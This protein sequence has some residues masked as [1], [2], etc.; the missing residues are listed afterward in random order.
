MTSRRGLW[1]LAV[2][3]LLGLLVVGKFAA[4]RSSLPRVWARTVPV[5]PSDPLR[6]RYVR[7][8][9]DAEDHRAAGDSTAGVEFFA[10]D[11]VLAVRPAR[12]GRG[13]RGRG[14][15]P[16]GAAGGGVWAPGANF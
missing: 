8:W 6:G 1:L 13:V 9:L 4:D 15:A 12:G 5:D 14:P 11:G 7:L 10:R 2:Q 3:L 16:P